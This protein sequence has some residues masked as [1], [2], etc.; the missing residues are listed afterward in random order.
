M[1]PVRRAFP[2]RAAPLLRGRFTHSIARAVLCCRRCSSPFTVQS[3]RF[4]CT[5]ARYCSTF[6][7]ANHHNS[8]SS[9]IHGGAEEG[10]ADSAITTAALRA[11]RDGPL[12]ARC[13]EMRSELE[14]LERIK[15]LCD[16]A[17]QRHLDR[18]MQQLF[19]LLLFQAVVLFDWTY[20]HF[21]WN[22]V[23]P[24]TYLI[25]YS[26]TWIAILWY[27]ALQREFSYDTLRDMLREQQ[28][29]RLYAQHKFD[30]AHYEKVKV[31]VDRLQRVLRSL[32][33]L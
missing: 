33:P 2:P 5:T 1:L 26:A 10:G 8:R 16:A 19:L 12:K 27:G 11:A 22:L 23:E 21:D 9:G 29:E 15:N 25:G 30:L 17:A 7:A 31:E 24:I 13:S 6:T 4:H 18:K 3:S 32:E 20:V 14:E 28:C